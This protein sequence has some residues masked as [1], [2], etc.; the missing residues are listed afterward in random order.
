MNTYAKDQEFWINYDFGGKFVY[1]VYRVYNLR[2]RHET[3]LN[4]VVMIQ[5]DNECE[6]IEIGLEIEVEMKVMALCRQV[7]LVVPYCVSSVCC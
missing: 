4:Y 1:Y 3:L 5:F 7:E 2:K 6:I